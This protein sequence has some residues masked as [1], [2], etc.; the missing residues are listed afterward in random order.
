MPQIRAFLFLVLVVLAGLRNL[1]LAAETAAGPDL[2][3]QKTLYA[4]GYAHLDT[5]W[6]WTYVDTINGCLR[7]TLYDNFRL[8]EKY[9]H[10]VFNFS[11]AN[12]YRMMAEYYPAEYAKLK[13]WVA[14]GRWFPCGS[15]WEENDVN[16]PSSESLIRQILFGREYFRREFGV[17]SAE[18]MLPDC[19]GF[20][21]SLPSV[22]AHCGLRGFST[23]KLTWGSAVGIPF[24]VGVWRG[25]DGR[26][27]IAAL[28][29]G[30]YGGH[31][32]ENLATSKAWLK[33]IEENAARGGLFTD[34]HYYG[35]GDQ[36]GAPSEGSVQWIE[37]ALATKGPLKVVSAKADQMFRD[38]SD[39]QKE[40]LPVYQG[41]LLLTEHSAGSITSQA[42]MKRWNHM[43]ENLA[44]AAEKA[45]VAAD[46]LGASPYPR[47]KLHNA[48]GLVLGSQFHDMLPG[49][50]TPKAYEYC[51][52]DELVAMNS[53]A[54]A[55]TE[56]VRGVA[57]GLDTRIAGGSSGVPLVVF[58][59]LS[60]DREDVVE[61]AENLDAAAVQICDGAGNAVP[62]Q[63]VEGPNGRRVLFL[64]RVPALSFAVFSARPSSSSAT[65]GELKASANRLENARYR[66][67]I[68]AAGDIASV[69]DKLAGRELLAEPSRLALLYENPSLYP[70]WN[71]DWADRQKPPVGYVEGPAAIR[72]AE[73]GPVRV[74]LEVTRHGE[75]S[76]FVQTIRLA[77]GAAGERV[78]VA[79]NVN[80][81]GRERSL[82]A[83]FPLTVAN[84]LATYNWELGK[85]QRGNNEP[86]K[87]EVPAHQWFDL[88]DTKGDYGVSVLSDYKYGS[89]KPADNQLR[90]TLLYTPGTRGGYGD[91]ASQDWGRHEFT[92]ALFGHRG[93]WQQSDV[94]W[95]AARLGRPMAVFAAAP[96]G[97]VLGHTFTLLRSSSEQVAIQAVKLPEEPATGKGL[98]KDIVVRVQELHGKP[99]HNVRISSMPNSDGLKDIRAAAELDGVERTLGPLPLDHGELALDFTPYQVRT[100]RLTV[101]ARWGL[102]EASRSAPVAIPYD[103]CAFSRR[104][105]KPTRGFDEQNRTMPGDR[106]G[107]TLVSDGITY[108]LG[109]R[110]ADQ[111]SALTCRGQMLQ[112]PSGQWSDIYLLVARNGRDKQALSWSG[113]IGQWDR[114]IFGHGRPTAIETGYINRDPVAWFCSHRNTADGGH[115][116]Y[117][118][119]YLYT[120]TQPLPRGARTF[121]L[122]TDESLR[123]FAVSAA[124]HYGGTVT[125]LAPLYDDFS[126]RQPVELIGGTDRLTAGLKPAG[127]AAIDRKATFAQLSMGAPSASD[128]ADAASGH[129]VTFSYVK[130]RGR[131]TPH[132]DSGAKGTRLPRLN[133]GQAAQ[134]SDDTS[135][136]VWFN[137][138]GRFCA[139][140]Q[141]SLPI[142]AVNTYSWHNSNRAPQKFTLW[143]SNAAH[144]PPPTFAQGKGS[145]WTLLGDVD[146][147]P[148]GEGGVHGSAVT[149]RD[150][151]P[152][153][154]FRYLL[155]IAEDVGEGSFFTEIDVHEAK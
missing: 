151:K 147:W 125:P 15:S 6:R 109:P 97:G 71:M 63:N 18:F 87:Y 126:N 34:Y 113:Y 93:S 52:N 28:N 134:N 30:N 51:W 19:F 103:V 84:P 47:E 89:D 25:P 50:S 135:R 104:G 4:V 2:S 136:C 148:L 85:V 21:A 22:L 48:W 129:G 152:L 131:Y 128:Y 88:T 121:Q 31:V 118:Y 35:I 117:A 75:N 56:G 111:P 140:L 32:D 90:L 17:E 145:G 112:L 78:E 120:Q 124:K 8:L 9:P 106:I 133:D 40:K 60:V 114:R 108:K 146:T 16:V 153:G 102:R 44:D 5:Q 139:D 36:G 115:E 13:Q 43:N 100:L 94:D 95:Q 20:P 45:S 119:S 149:G 14:S 42:Y 110:A 122:P 65:G 137:H 132:H 55:L 66:V 82:K 26:S 142:Q 91:Q 67:T 123:V 11:G 107:D 24:N 53:F 150:G 23:Q 143:G 37:K 141:K 68:N 10:Y 101:G 41:D 49:T 83:V 77:A 54:A 74:A 92:Y 144:M 29:P 130:D 58:N 76:T 57:E 86:K 98:W 96:H 46:L 79:C 99:A 154:S 7:R 33:R 62:T 72:V 70:A 80:W 59:P 127:K 3:K 116:T 38:I 138:E 73:N 12:R 64:A 155:W 39:A 1:G 69:F 105:E 27:V 61:L 81:Q